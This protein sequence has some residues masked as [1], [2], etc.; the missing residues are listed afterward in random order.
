VIRNQFE[1]EVE[2]GEPENVGQLNPPR[3]IDGFRTPLAGVDL[4]IAPVPPIIS[5]TKSQRAALQVAT[6]S[7]S[8]FA[9]AK[10][11]PR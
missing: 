5:R 8:S 9:A 10:S 1:I 2:T 4:A 11:E 7:A 6:A 3:P